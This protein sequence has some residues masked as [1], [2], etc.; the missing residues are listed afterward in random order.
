M[1]NRVLF[2]AGPFHGGLLFVLA[3]DI[4]KIWW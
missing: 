4:K 2:R 3:L 1:V